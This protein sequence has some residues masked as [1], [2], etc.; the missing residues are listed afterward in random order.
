MSKYLWRELI[1]L[2]SPGKAYASP[3]A[4]LAHVDANAFFAQ[5]EQIRTGH[6]KEDP[7]VCV[8]WNSLIA[9]SYA[10][11]KY[12]I[13][14]MDSVD[15]ALKKCP[16]LIPVHTAT[17]KKGEDFWQYRDDS[18]S[19]VEDPSKQLSVDDYKVSLEPYRRESRKLVKIFK[20]QCDLVEKVSVDEVYLDLSR[21][22]F[23]IIMSETNHPHA[24]YF[25]SIRDTFVRGEYDLNGTLPQVP[26]ELR[27]VLKFEGFAYKDDFGIE[28]WDDV[29]LA[30][31]S[32]ECQRIRDMIEDNLGYTTSA[33]VANTKTICKL[34]SNYR[35]PNQQTIIRNSVI[36]EF[37]DNEG[38]DITSFGSLGGQQGKELEQ[39][40]ELPSN[41]GTIKYVREQWPHDHLQLKAYI[42]ER[43][44]L[45]ELR[46]NLTTIDINRT[47]ALAERIFGFVRG[48][49]RV[50]LNEKP[51]VKSM[52]SNKNMRNQACANLLDCIAWLEVF[53]G[54][55]S[56]RVFD[57]AQ[58]VNK[59]VLP[60]TVTISLKTKDRI[61][62]RKSG[63]L[64]Y[65]STEFKGHELL[66][67]ATKLIKEIDE[68]YSSTKNYYP[69]VNLNMTISNFDILDSK[70]TVVDMF[71]RKS[72]TYDKVDSIR[73]SKK[74]ESASPSPQTTDTTSIW[75]CETCNLTFDELKYFQEHMDFH[76]AKKLSES[77]NGVQEDSQSLSVGE[78]RL[79]FSKDRRSNNYSGKIAKKNSSSKKSGST[80]NILSFFGRK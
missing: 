12:G 33:G 47:E 57:L 28:D 69:L 24:A 43:M 60:R 26:M 61:A 2:N 41:G 9:V 42:D 40:L 73:P 15:D 75:T 76:A 45:P 51:V 68:Q 66:P 56:A 37:L 16:H 10:A 32:Q 49:Y 13:S 27:K 50:P 25:A 72:V 34:G 65:R 39:L 62:Y 6:T 18:G 79:L 77:L 14:R 22:A 21:H 3:L 46:K 67:C 1:Q 48:Q 11:R 52:M 35:K 59:I 8:Q 70:K 36:T 58:E 71:G 54:E 64:I 17:F 30:Y 29:I 63:P 78:K 20:E 44:K 7:I 74:Q 38:F 4:C 31:G 5:V 80:G 55:L 23:R 19:W 53:C